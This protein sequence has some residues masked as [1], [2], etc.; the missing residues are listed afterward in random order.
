M[1]AKSVFE[2]VYSGVNGY[3]IS[4]AAR[5]KMAYMDKAHTYGEVTP[6]GFYKMLND[7]SAPKKGVFYDLGS[8]TGKAV[9]LSSMFGE[10][11]K[12]YGVELI[13]D[14]Y[15]AACRVENK[16]EETVRPILTKERQNQTIKFINGNFL[17][18]DFQDADFIFTHSTCFH[19]ELMLALERKFAN[20][21]EGTKILT[22]TKTLQL[23]FKTL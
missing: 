4:Q 14:L 10:F 11:E 15:D 13:K 23:P 6:E 21:R 2:S 12:L 5:K 9:I 18:V 19:D 8:G 16:F 22:V 20:L 1:V 7:I 3:T 17:E